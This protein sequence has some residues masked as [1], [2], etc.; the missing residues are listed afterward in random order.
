[1]L[2]FPGTNMHDLNLDWIL[3]EIKR[4][5]DTIDAIIQALADAGIT[6]E[7]SFTD[8]TTFIQATSKPITITQNTIQPMAVIKTS[9]VEYQQINIKHTGTTFTTPT[10]S[11]GTSLAGYIEFG[12]GTTSLLNLLTS[13]DYTDSQTEHTIS[14]K[15]R[16]ADTIE[17]DN[18]DGI[19]A[20]DLS[21]F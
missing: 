15:T 20:I 19:I 6:V 11:G 8:G 4:L 16:N 9:D 2:Q 17:I 7:V 3:V 1:M 21:N 5:S 13:Y 18:C 14:I 10:I 12:D